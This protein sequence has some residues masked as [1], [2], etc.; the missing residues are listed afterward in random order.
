MLLLL[1]FLHPTQ[2]LLPLLPS[3]DGPPLHMPDAPLC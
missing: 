2:I 1:L 3:V